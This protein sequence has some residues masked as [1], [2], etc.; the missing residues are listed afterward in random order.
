MGFLVNQFQALITAND[1]AALASVKALIDFFGDNASLIIYYSIGSFV[2][3]FQVGGFS[4]ITIS[5]DF[6][7]AIRGDIPGLFE[8]KT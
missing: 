5:G 6:Y 1:A 7:N 8:P 2:I 4:Q 3:G